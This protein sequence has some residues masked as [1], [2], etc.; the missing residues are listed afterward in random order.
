MRAE[1]GPLKDPSRSL[2]ASV[3]LSPD[4][5]RLR[6]GWRLLA[7][8]ILLLVLLSG[9][10]MAVI[11]AA[12]IAGPEPFSVQPLSLLELAP[13]AVAVALSVWIARR[14]IDRRSFVSL[15]LRLDR[16]APLDVLVGFLVAGTA[17]AG[18]YVVEAGAGWLRFDGWAW[19]AMPA[20][21][22]ALQLVAALLGFTLVGYYEELLSRGYHLQNIQDGIGLGWGVFLSSVVFA[23]M[24]IANPNTT[25]YSV[26]LGLT[27]AGGFFAF[28]W[29]RTRQ[30]WMPIGL[31]I[32]WNFF[33]GNVFGFPVSGIGVMGLIRQAPTGPVALTGGAFGPEAGLIVL[34]AMAVGVGL[35]WLYTRGRSPASST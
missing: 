25:W 33:E 24:H 34:P 28:G 35:I 11:V 1:K 2:L 16:R 4:E 23:L 6:A 30:L 15:G 7:H 26:L 10:T 9:T 13:T 5:R 14:L 20:G 17:V 12:V 21:Q 27:A 18:I 19:E 32:G 8:S 31:H 3:F 22:V 29:I